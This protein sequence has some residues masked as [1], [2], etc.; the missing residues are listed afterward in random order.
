MITP[1]SVILTIVAVLLAALAW[2]VFGILGE[3]DSGG[4]AADSYGTRN[5]G[6]RGLYETMTE[7]G[8]PVSRSLAPPGA[9]VAL[10]TTVVLWRPHG[11]L[12]MHEP[13]FLQEL[14]DWVKS[15]GRVVLTPPAGISPL[16]A[17]RDMG[18][19]GKDENETLW[20]AMHLAEF[21]PVAIDAPV[22]DAVTP[23]RSS[24]DASPEF[25]NFFNPP[26][27]SVSVDVEARGAL[28][29]LSADVRQLE[30]SQDGWG[31]I[32]LG[33]GESNGELV[34]TDENGD[35][36]AAIRRFAVGQGEVVVVGDPRLF[37]NWFLAKADNSVLAVRLLLGDREQVQFNEFYHGLSVRGNPLWLLT[38]RG[39]ALLAAAVIGVVALITWRSAVLLGPPLSTPEPS[40]RTVAE[41]VDAMSRF[42]DRGRRTRTQLLQE[43]YLGTLRSIAAE[44]QM[45]TSREDAR[46]V[47]KVVARREPGRAERLRAAAT[48]VD[49]VLAKHDKATEHET[50]TALQML[51]DCQ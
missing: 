29:P 24:F 18:L 51:H 1:R 32:D 45:T 6:Q 30:L 8:L 34:W 19:P 49:A 42:L 4:R 11:N 50:V 9:D 15:G 31:A 39:Y 3:P 27:R 12:V 5:D 21:R 17:M 2:G 48:A 38:R 22:T 7:L 47:A 10:N 33:S 16:Q 13:R 23:R 41:Y 46:A 43:V 40:R 36:H 35:E 14:G 20:D 28:A 44:H 26:L 25:K 37:G